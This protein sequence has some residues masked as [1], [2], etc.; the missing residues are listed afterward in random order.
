MVRA[1]VILVTEC[2]DD[3][4]FFVVCPFCDSPLEPYSTFYDDYVDENWLCLCRCEKYLMCKFLETGDDDKC[5]IKMSPEEVQAVCKKYDLCYTEG[6]TRGY[7]VAVL[8]L[9]FVL[10]HDQILD[11]DICEDVRRAYID[12]S[13]TRGLHIT[14]ECFSLNEPDVDL[15]HDGVNV[16]YVGEC[17]EC[18]EEYTSTFWGD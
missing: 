15:S 2:Y 6:E 3:E 14:E 1:T 18:G 11:G 13:G 10:P 16:G 17:S 5:T 4:G 7:K 8:K 9:K 12:K